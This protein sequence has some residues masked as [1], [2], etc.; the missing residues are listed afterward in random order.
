M[1]W[2]FWVLIILF[3]IYVLDLVLILILENRDP[4]KT[5]AWILVLIFLP[6]IGTIAYFFLGESIKRKYYA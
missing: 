5:L 6:V 4:Y 3:L 1:L 2:V